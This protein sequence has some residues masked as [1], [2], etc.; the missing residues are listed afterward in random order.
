MYYP[1][2]HET[3][4]F[5]INHSVRPCVINIYPSASA[6]IIDE[7][8]NTLQLQLLGATQVTQ[9]QTLL[10]EARKVIRRKVESFFMKPP[11]I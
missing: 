9:D 11:N 7:V 6:K 4:H 10:C 1:V 2:L 8:T 3:I 5:S